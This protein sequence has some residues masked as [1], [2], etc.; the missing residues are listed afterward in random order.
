MLQP[1]PA[2]RVPRIDRGHDESTPTIAALYDAHLN[3]VYGFCRSRLAQHDAEDLTAEVFRAAA[4]RLAV[5][6]TVR[7]DESWLIVTARNRIIDRWRRESRWR[8]R[9]AMI[10]SSLRASDP[11]H[12]DRLVDTE[13]VTAAL[14]R[15]TGSHRAVLVL[16]Y[17]EDLP[18][19]E[20]ASILD[21]RVAAVESLLV[22]AR[23]AFDAAL[24]EEGFDG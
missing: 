9:Q 21:R 4:E 15:L 19:S 14:D 5:D 11:D 17:L 24:A 6:P 7:L 18:V 12:S 1:N 3:R 23:R 22:R 2:A 13:L 16:R 20:V 8:R 10:N